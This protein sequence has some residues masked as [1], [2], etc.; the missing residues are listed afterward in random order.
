M[1]YLLI[2]F[3]FFLI[4][5]LV[6]D[7]LRFKGKSE[8][9]Y[10]EVDKYSY[11]IEQEPANPMHYCKRGTAYQISQNFINANLDFRKA[12]D[13][14]E[15]GSSVDNKELIIGKLKINIEYTTKP[16]TWSKNGPR[17][18]S[19]NFLMYSLIDRLGNMRYNF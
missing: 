14:I 7:W 13:L 8:R 17:D 9:A 10:Y 18:Y 15:E 3:I 6:V 4:Y 12:L 16:L 2:A 5:S 1:I 11:L 19:K